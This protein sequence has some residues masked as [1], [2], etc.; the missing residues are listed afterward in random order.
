MTDLYPFMNAASA[1][2]PVLSTIYYLLRRNSAVLDKSRRI[3][4]CKAAKNAAGKKRKR[5]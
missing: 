2:V 4:K 3:V 1:K 5:S